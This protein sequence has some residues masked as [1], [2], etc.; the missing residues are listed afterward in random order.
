VQLHSAKGR[1]HLV[2]ALPSVALGKGPSVN[3]F[4]AKALCRVP[5]IGVLGKGFV[6]CQEGTWQRKVGCDGADPLTV[7]LP[8]AG[9]AGT[10]Q[11]F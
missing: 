7:G 5:F 4:T 11:I 6:E 1:F 8:S 9:P 10:R 3:F 2:K